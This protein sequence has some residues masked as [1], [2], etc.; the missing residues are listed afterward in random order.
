MKGTGEPKSYS[1]CYP[2]VQSR[3]NLQSVHAPVQCHQP[4][5]HARWSPQPL[6]NFR[7]YLLSKSHWK[8]S[9]PKPRT[10]TARTELLLAACMTVQ[11]TGAFLHLLGGARDNLEL[12]KGGNAEGKEPEQSELRVGLPALE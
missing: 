11:N 8:T 2:L 12:Q 1:H 6:Q 10:E 5:L 7:T 4:S 3:S 9:N